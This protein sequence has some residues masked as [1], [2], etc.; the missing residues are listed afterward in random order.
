[1]YSPEITRLT[2]L[3]TGA[4]MEVTPDLDDRLC[5]TMLI[6]R[7]ILDDTDLRRLRRGWMMRLV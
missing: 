3:V 1:M 6:G 7:Y 2:N 4:V 5:C